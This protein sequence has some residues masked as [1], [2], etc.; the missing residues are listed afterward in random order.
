MTTYTL[1]GF[2]TEVRLGLNDY[3][4]FSDQSVPVPTAPF[5]RTSELRL[6]VPE[7]AGFSFTPTEIGTNSN[8]FTPGDQLFGLTRTH[9]VGPGGLIPEAIDIGYTLS[10]ITWSGGKT[11][12]LTIHSFGYES[13][14]ALSGSPLPEITS[15]SDYDAFNESITNRSPV[16][17]SLEPNQSLDWDLDTVSRTENDSFAGT[18]GSD[19]LNGGLG[20]DS[21]NGIAGD[22]E[23]NGNLGND[24]LIGGIGSD[25]VQGGNGDD[26]VKGGSGA[27]EVRGGNGRDQ[28]YGGSGQDLG[29]GGNGR[30][31]MH[32]G[33]GT[34][35]LLGGNQADVLY[36]NADS[37][38]LLG[39][40]GNDT[41]QGSNGRDSVH[42]GAGDDEVRGGNGN[43]YVTGGDQNDLVFG[44]NGRDTLDG[45]SGN[46]TLLGGDG[47][48]DLNGG[49]GNDQLNGGSGNDVLRGGAFNQERFLPPLSYMIAAP[50][51]D[52]VLEDTG[53]DTLDGGQGRDT[54]DGGLGDDLLTGGA[55]DD[56]FVFW[57]GFGS[58][59]NDTI[60]DFDA[61]S[62]GEVID[63]STVSSITDMADLL[64]NHIRQ[65]GEDVL[66]ED[67]HGS[68]ITLLNVNLADLDET[69]FNFDIPMR[70]FCP[71][72]EDWFKPTVIGREAD[73]NDTVPSE[74]DEQA[75][76]EDYPAPRMDDN[77]VLTASRPWDPCPGMVDWDLA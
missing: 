74:E 39:G 65:E 64:E 26:E 9:T 6:S 71:V 22:D 28:V 4:D 49:I 7:G 46:D 57:D 13:V 37:D 17:G 58:F 8:V 34:D 60:T 18:F 68:T 5:S 24:V 47:R 69:D 16:T 15:R 72:G 42:G 35:T 66:I 33:H 52:M 77:L 56:W 23:L 27:D 30:D 20:D 19:L 59:G 75:H 73:A 11:V 61:A 38:S 76:C 36:G 55:G 51:H 43:D 50:T 53:N 54:L 44:G 70:N 25:T 1:T 29:Y 10:E 45:G 62:S 67:A 63:L 3:P 12:I 31:T 2:L 32:G 48:D 21:I 41:L 14:Y 40:Q